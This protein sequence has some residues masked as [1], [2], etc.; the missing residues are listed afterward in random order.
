MSRNVLIVTPSLHAGGAEVHAV[1]A[2]L[3]LDRRRWNPHVLSFGDGPLRDRLIGAGVSHEVRPLPDSG[4]G[5]LE[6]ARLVRKTLTRNQSHAISGH[7]VFTEFAVRLA[8]RGD[9]VPYLAWKHTYGH[10]GY[11]G[12][13]ERIFEQLTGQAVTR[14]GAVC[15]SQVRY[16]MDDLRLPAPKISVVPNA[17][18]APA[19]PRSLPPAVAPTVLMVA[20]MRAD[21]GHELVLRAMR[22]VL[23]QHPETRLRLVGDGPCRE[24]L[25]RTV[26][27]LGL[28]E[29]VEFLGVRSD[30]DSLMQDAHLLVLASYN[31]ECF[32]YAALEAMAAGRGVVSTNVGGLPELIDDGV[33]GRLIS[34]GDPVSLGRAIIE[35][36]DDGLSER[37]R[38][39]RAG[40]ERV[41]RVHSMNRWTQ[42]FADL[43]DDITVASTSLPVEMPAKGM[44]E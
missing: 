28:A 13:R 26:R 4:R 33:T 5:I 12:L 38:W 7:G 14:Y 19:T 27:E 10:I 41:Q 43:L 34:P 36:L 16:L 30:I 15:H 42:Q 6:A 37:P 1:L 31:I 24:N 8:L 32:P 40:W 39:G 25:Q 17:V 23:A 20:A 22:Q 9:A 35:G 21:K 29:R 11:R 44:S 2:A 3:H 18:P